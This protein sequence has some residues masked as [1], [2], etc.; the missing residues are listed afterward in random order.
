MCFYM[1]FFSAE[2]GCFLKMP[3]ELWVNQLEELDISWKTDIL[4]VFEYYTER[5]PGMAFIPIFRLVY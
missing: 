1:Q 5:T 4:S 2:H 3:G